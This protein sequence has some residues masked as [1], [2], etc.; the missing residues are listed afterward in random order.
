MRPLP[1]SGER[2][3]QKFNKE[4][5]VRGLSRAVL[6]E[7]PPHPAVCVE[8]LALPSPRKQGEGADTSAARDGL[9]HLQI[10]EALALQ[11]GDRRDT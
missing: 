3:A 8:T 11:L 7:S 1:A 2:A 4:E 9:P 10:R 6:V 5:R